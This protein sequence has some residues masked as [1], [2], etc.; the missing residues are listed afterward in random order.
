M[1]TNS[2]NPTRGVLLV[3][4]AVFLFAL[5]DVLTKHL[6]EHFAVPIIVA[7]RYLVNL[8]LLAVVLW[9][10]YRAALWHTNRTWLV[11]LRALC[12]AAASLTMGLA[13]RVMPVGE[14]VAIVYLAP[15]L[16]MLLAVP[17]LGEKVSWIGW[18]AAICGFFGVLLIARPGGGLD[19]WGVTLAL[20]NVCFIA[21]YHL[22]TRFLARTETTNA[23]LFHTALLG[24]LVFVM[25]VLVAP[26]TSPSTGAP[27][28][29]DMA[30]MG[31][32]GAIAAAGHF[33]FTAAYRHA[34]SSLLAPVNY[35]HL[36]WSAG[37]GWLFFNHIPAG[38]S[39][40]GIVMVMTAGVAAALRS[41]AM[42]RARPVVQPG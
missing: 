30:L 16:V 9:P 25:M 14:T 38:W 26:G 4:A 2:S 11:L 10:R 34:P 1:P 7:V 3:C 24:S 23:L 27:G 21:A 29:L 35:L 41:Q 19:P 42:S 32:L 13:L 6:A 12:L 5:S 20:I 37:L 15:F 18:L 8:A 40:L 22:L 36:V 17:L 33:L 39:L 28:L 31:L